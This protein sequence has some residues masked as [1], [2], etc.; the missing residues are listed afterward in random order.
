MSNKKLERVLQLIINEETD[1]ANDLLHDIFVENARNIYLDMVKE[2]EDLERI[3]SEADDDEYDF[4]V[5]DMEDDLED[6]VSDE[7]DTYD[8]EI[9]SEEM[10]EEEDEEED[11]ME[12][13]DMDDAEMDLEDEMGGD[14]MDMD[15]DDES[16]MD[17][18]SEMESDDDGAQEAF[19]NVE[20]AL[21]ELK[22]YFS[23]LVGDG[24]SDEDDFSA[25]DDYEYG[26][27][28][29]DDMGMDMDDE[30]DMDMGMDDEDE[31]KES[32]QLKKVSAPSN[33]KGDDG[34]SSPI[35]KGKGD[36]LGKPMKDAIKNT[37]ETGGKAQ[38]PKEMGIPGPESVGTKMK[39]APTR[40][41]KG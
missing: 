36:K 17:M 24:E 25:G 11:D 23:D 30:S 37:T 39:P 28:E 22:S 27:D 5:S 16:D 14:E 33:K 26:E 20:D 4:D 1:K 13:M 7:V 15:M 34:K 12:D 2:D 9:D 6:D 38:K 10:Y 35:A 19:M 32:L 3:M 21:E 41:M 40:N 18:D 8:S 31:I 29:G